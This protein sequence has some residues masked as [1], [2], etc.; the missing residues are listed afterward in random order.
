[1]SVDSLQTLSD[2][3]NDPL[4]SAAITSFATM[5]HPRATGLLIAAL[6]VPVPL[7]AQPATATRE[8]DL[9]RLEGPRTVLSRDAAR[10]LDPEAARVTLRPGEYVVGQWTGGAAPVKPAVAPDGQAWVLEFGFIGVTQDGREIRFRPVIET[11][12]GLV[13]SGD[14]FSGLIH[15]GLRDIRD[16]TAQ[17]ELPRPI[18]LLVSGQAEEVAPR[19]LTL[20][21]TNLPFADVRISARDPADAVELI[22]QASGTTERAM[23]TVPVSRPRLELA[24]ARSHIQGFG[25]ETSPLTVRAVGFPNPEGRLVT[26]GSRLGSV[27][28]AAVTLDAGGTATTIIRSGLVGTTVI[29]ASAPPFSPASQ[30]IVFEWPIAFM[31]AAII[32]GLAGAYL[33]H[34]TLKGALGTGVLTGVLAAAL[35]AVGVNVLPIQPTARTGEVLVFVVAAVG[36][37]VGLTFGGSP[38]ARRDTP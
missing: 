36:A 14:G 17:Y 31:I 7:P 15:V 30:P 24:L 27:E 6:F 38:T 28:P 3:P 9:Q 32:G 26:I 4:S 25:L 10:K 29:E 37:Y 18:G 21:H 8:V 35:Y 16:P 13:A 1:M 34:R 23:V 22:V 33:R 11:A 19:Q 2:N 5:T 12:G 20:R